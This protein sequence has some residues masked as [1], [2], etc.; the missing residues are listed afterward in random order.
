MANDAGVWDLHGLVWEWVEDFN[1]SLVTGESRADAALERSLFC[2]SG[3]LG[4]SAFL[5][6][7]AFMRQALRS[8]LR[9]S[10]TMRNLGFRCACD[11]KENP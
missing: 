5:D 8:S 6:Y 4:A 7:A 1:S 10:Y 9:A 3:A 2:G 11:D